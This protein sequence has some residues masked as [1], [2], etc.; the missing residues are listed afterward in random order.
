MVNLQSLNRRRRKQCSAH[1]LFIYVTLYEPVTKLYSDLY[2][3]YVALHM[4]RRQSDQR[5]P[6]VVQWYT[7]S[8]TTHGT[9]QMWSYIA[10]GLSIQV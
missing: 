9:M 10:F 5:S 6:L 4:C 3:T 1:K 7:I 8:K 2:S